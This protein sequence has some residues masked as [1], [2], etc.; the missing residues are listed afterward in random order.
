MGGGCYGVDVHHGDEAE[1]QERWQEPKVSQF[2]VRQML[3]W[4]YDTSTGAATGAAR[5]GSFVGKG[6]SL[7]VVSSRW[8]QGF[9]WFDPSER[10]TL[11]PW[12]N[13]VVLLKPGLTCVSLSLSFFFLPL[14]WR[15][16]GPFIGQ[17]RTVTTS[18]KARQLAP[19]Q[20]GPYAIGHQW[21]GVANDFFNGV[22]MSGLAAY[23]AALGQ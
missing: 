11:C 7:L 20:V 22:G 16:P 13:G 6:F 19:G 18:L 21:L 12:E 10:N 17:G 23:H 15:L 14:D 9:M 5:C 1:N 4:I 2:L 3:K 8:T